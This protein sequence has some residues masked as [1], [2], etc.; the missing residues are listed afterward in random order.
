MK[1]R[2]FLTPLEEEESHSPYTNEREGAASVATKDSNLH[3]RR[4]KMTETE[5]PE[6]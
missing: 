4:S 6:G 5:G 2:E 1:K 3:L